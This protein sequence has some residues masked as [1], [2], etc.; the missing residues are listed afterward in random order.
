MVGVSVGQF[1]CASLQVTGALKCGVICPRLLWGLGGTW[2]ARWYIDGNR[3][4]SVLP[5]GWHPQTL[6]K[7]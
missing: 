7:L 3:S 5:L 2:G 6:A 1:L 4:L